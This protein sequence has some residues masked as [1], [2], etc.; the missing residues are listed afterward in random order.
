MIKF[1]REVLLKGTKNRS[2]PYIFLVLCF[3]AVV[4]FI[5]EGIFWEPIHVQ[6]RLVLNT[7]NL[8]SFI[9]LNRSR[10]SDAVIGFT[11]PMIFI[12][13]LVIGSLVMGG[14]FNLFI[15]AIG[16]AIISLTYLKPKALLLYVITYSTATGIIIFVFGI[17]LLGYEFSII[18][19]AIYWLC[20]AGINVMLYIF[21][22]FYE[23]MI[24]TLTE[25]KNNLE[26]ATKAKSQFLATMSHEIR[27]PMNAIIGI[28]QMQLQKNNN[29]DD[30]LAW[31]RV[32]M[33]GSTLLGIINDILD[34]SK[35][36]AGKL[37]L[38]PS[39]YDV[40]KLIH[41]SAQLNAMRIG[42]KE[43][44]FLLE[45]DKK[46][47]EK[48]FGDELRIRQILNNLLSN[49]FKYTEKGSV[50]LSISHD[51]IADD[52]VLLTLTVE[53]T[54]QGMKKEDSA[55]LFSEEYVRF[56]AESNRVIEGTGIG[57]NITQT[58]T[59]MMDG[60]VAVESE[61]GKGSIFTVKLKQKT[62]PGT[63]P[64]GALVSKKLTHF[65]FSD[66][67][68][69]QNLSFEI[70]PYGTVLIVDDVDINLYVAEGL[71]SPYEL[72]IETA[73]SGFQAIELLETK[74]YDI[75]FM[76]HMMPQMDGIETTRR[77][78]EKGYQ[79][80]IIAL[81]ANALVG[82]DK[83]FKDN[84][85][86]DFIAKPI[87]VRELNDKLNQWVRDKHPDEAKKH[88]P[89]LLKADNAKAPDIDK[90]LIEV[91]LGDAKKAAI[92]L[93]ETVAS[94]DMKL[95][96]ITIH[97]MKSALANIGEKEK[98]VLAGRLEEAGRES[99]AAFISAHFGGFIDSLES[100]IK[101]L[102]GVVTDVAKVVDDSAV[103][104]DSVYLKEQLMMIKIACDEY[105]E[106]AIYGILDKIKEKEWKNETLKGLDEINRLIFFESD[107][108]G[109]AGV[110]EAI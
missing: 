87:D 64:I 14:D 105:D 81:T 53:D 88:K 43:I 101:K 36:E 40:P 85:F 73:T 92:T 45:A 11:Y 51:E 22:K 65:A 69:R 91:F 82:N 55:K 6:I 103:V 57:L 15:Y 25:T 74:S 107:F 109:A 23:T 21:C 27:T 59:A 7:I 83:M 8:S 18:I 33:S 38:N 89:K 62:I 4:L 39:A 48:L 63:A 78:R 86:D 70:M 61:Y 10:L 34:L 52:E 9:L 106:K 41:D 32:Y 20:A 76:D 104:E 16:A 99:D 98:S 80:T 30:I 17:N 108:E 50:K 19:N 28:T 44:K 35:I 94:H 56:N 79:G 90:K 47:P 66:Q 49:A 42:E 31:E 71:M 96:T 75:V 2:A 72:Q 54:G 13:N 110:A 84:G 5:Y 97:A 102:S 67:K 46:L 29:P 24:R 1:I 12:T 37:E 58:L 60:S 3:Y 68:E 77:I 26:V 93:R 100:L 95:F